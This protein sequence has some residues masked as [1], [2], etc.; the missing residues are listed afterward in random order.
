MEPLA[1]A[2]E[3]GDFQPRHQWTTPR[4]A[5][6]FR[7]RKM[8]FSRTEGSPCAALAAER[9]LRNLAVGFGNAPS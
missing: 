7:W 4:L 1:K 9:W 8:N 3:Q 2:T 6:L 5:E